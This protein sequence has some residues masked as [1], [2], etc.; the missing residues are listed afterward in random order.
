MSDHDQTRAAIWMQIREIQRRHAQE[1]APYF[2]RLYALQALRPPR[3]IIV[4]ADQVPDWLRQPD[5]I[6]GIANERGELCA[7]VA[8]ST[9]NGDPGD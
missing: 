5:T 9:R 8:Q 1:L 3:P 7:V 6:G 2:E 4:S